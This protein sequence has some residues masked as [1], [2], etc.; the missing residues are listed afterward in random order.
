MERINVNGIIINEIILNENVKIKK[1]NN[2]YELEFKTSNYE[3]I[4]SLLKTRII[5][6]GSTDQ[7][8]KRIYF[9]AD[10]VKTLKQYKHDKKMTTGKHVLSVSD[11]AKLIRCSAIQLNYLIQTHNCSI[12]GYN[13][14]DILVINDTTFAYIGNELI[15]KIDEDTQCVMISCPYSTKDF[16][17]SP[18]FLAIK[19]IPAYIHFKSSYF[20]FGLL[21]IYALLE[22]DDFYSEYI[23]NYINNSDPKNHNNP[24]TILN[25]LNN[26]P[27]KNSKLYW[28]LSRCLV[29]EAKDRSIIL[30]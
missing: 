3:L 11:I 7:T 28:L 12:L 19:E 15:E 5:Q 13:P 27:I 4:N 16:L 9:K 14:E 18:E 26:H 1:E 6:G 2:I 22:E 25:V 23:N 21:I 8:Y 30:L 10:R 29:E 24:S 20:S 17:F